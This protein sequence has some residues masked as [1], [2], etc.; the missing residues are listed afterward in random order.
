MNLRALSVVGM[1]GL[2]AVACVKDKASP[3]KPARDAQLSDVPL[4]MP[5]ASPTSVSGKVVEVLKVT[6]YTYLN[7]ESDKGKVWAAVP[8]AEVKVGEDVTVANAMLMQPYHSSA[9]KRDFENV[10]FGTLV[11]ARASAPAHPSAE[12]PAPA[13]TNVHA[14][15]ATGPDAKTVEEVMARAADLKGKSVTVRGVVVKV[16]LKILGKNWVHIQDGTGSA[17][18]K[19]NDLLVTSSSEALPK[20]GE[21]VL[22][23]GSIATDQDFGS[24]YRYAALVENGTF[25]ASASPK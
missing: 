9:L 11:G 1:A 7:L 25:E 19:T 18:Q 20:V 6:T 10:Y 24:G 12:A 8:L 4:P 22:V 5:G 13:P 3:E 23:K 2:L 17:D 15:K 21:T 16:N 14:E